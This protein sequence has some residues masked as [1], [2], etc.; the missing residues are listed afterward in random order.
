M[1]FYFIVIKVTFAYLI[2]DQNVWTGPLCKFIRVSLEV[3][4]G[5]LNRLY[6]LVI[7]MI[8]TMNKKIISFPSKTTLNEL[9]AG[10]K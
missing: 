9:F 10:E 2:F 5:I 1:Y 3:Q 4:V 7:E 8:K 6:T